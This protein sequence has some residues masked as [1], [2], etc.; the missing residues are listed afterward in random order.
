MVEDVA[1]HTSYICRMKR[2]LAFHKHSLDNSSERF[3]CSHIL[4][5]ENR[6]HSAFLILTLNTLYKIVCDSLYQ[7][8]II[9]NH[10]DVIGVIFFLVQNGNQYAVSVTCWILSG[11]EHDIH[12]SLSP[13]NA[14]L[15]P[16]QYHIVRGSS[17][18]LELTMKSTLCCHNRISLQN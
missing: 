17:M 7:V 3:A 1:H 5:E 9:L 10:T 8:W 12:P 4:S 11:V 18:V 16:L 14:I 13:L 6:L 15:L 2:K